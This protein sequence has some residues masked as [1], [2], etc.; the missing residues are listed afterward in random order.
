MKASKE[1]L[2]SESE[3]ENL[4]KI[5]NR[6]YTWGEEGMWKISP[7]QRIT[8]QELEIRLKEEKILVLQKKAS[9]MTDCDTIGEFHQ[10]YF[11]VNEII[12]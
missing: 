6:A 5:I 2:L 8:S 4:V 9:H 12:N 10:R 3:M 11:I 1:D 7:V